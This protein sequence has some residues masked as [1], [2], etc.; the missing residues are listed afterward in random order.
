MTESKIHKVKLNAKAEAIAKIGFK[1]L[2]DSLSL[3]LTAIIVTIAVTVY[4]ATRSFW[5]TLISIIL[6]VLVLKY[7]KNFFIKLKHFIG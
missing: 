1:R 4:F 5:Y 7:G 6:V 2:W 3:N